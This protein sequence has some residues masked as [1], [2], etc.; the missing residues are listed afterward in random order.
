MVGQARK[1]TNGIRGTR[2]IP[3]EIQTQAAILEM[4]ELDPRVV[5]SARMNSGATTFEDRNG[6]RRYVHF[7]FTGCPD[8]IGQLAGGQL[9][10]LEVKKQGGR[11]RP[12]QRFFIDQARNAG[13]CAGI[14]R[15]VDD[16]IELIRSA[17]KRKEN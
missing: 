9:L 8:I 6:K 4:L 12:E 7:G 10:V 16:A 13:A 3:S 2:L 5:W 14:V 17:L 11:I 1:R 15:S